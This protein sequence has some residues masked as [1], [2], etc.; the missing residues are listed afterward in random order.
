MNADHNVLEMRIAAW[1]SREPTMLKF[2][3]E[4]VDIHLRTAMEMDKDA[5]IR[6][7]H[8]FLMQSGLP[9]DRT[10]TAVLSSLRNGLPQGERPETFLRLCCQEW[11]DQESW[12]RQWW[13]TGGAAEQQLERWGR[14]IPQIQETF[15][16]TLRERAFPIMS[17]SRLQSKEQ[18]RIEHRDAVQV[19][20]PE[21]APSLEKLLPGWIDRRQAAKAV[22]FGLLY[23][24]GEDVV[25]DAARKDYGIIMSMEEAKRAKQGYFELYPG[26]VEWHQSAR[27][28]VKKGY[29]ETPF[30]LVRSLSEF[31]GEN[32]G[33]LM[34]KAIN[35]PVQG[36]ASYI[37]LLGLVQVCDEIRRRGLEDVIWIT[38]FV[39]DNI[40]GEVREDY[41]EEAKEIVKDKMENLPLHLFG[42]EFD[43]PLV[44]DITFGRTWGG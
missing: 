20:S 33:A 40:L 11:P 15:L 4:D 1:M 2:L 9:P 41:Q 27:Q 38:D 22:G 17:P 12:N 14:H 13:A 39:H 34:R 3:K 19:L 16:R 31:S 43:V 37:A 23:G 6:T 28:W 35:T 25:V 5:T 8:L 44:A 18:P 30:G 10:G 26:L 36:T 21:R 42:I 29:I 32:D 7:A 24:G